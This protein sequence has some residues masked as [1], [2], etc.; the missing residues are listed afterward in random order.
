[1]QS[2]FQHRALFTCQRL[3]VHD[4]SIRAEPKYCDL[5]WVFCWL[6]ICDGLALLNWGELFWRVYNEYL[7]TLSQITQFFLIIIIFFFRAPSFVP[8]FVLS[9]SLFFYVFFALRERQLSGLLGLPAFASI[10]SIMLYCKLLVWWILLL[11]FCLFV[12][13]VIWK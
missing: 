7:D 4:W 6:F 11:M 3:I 2:S 8:S 12:I 5:R 10:L 9:V 1:M 13:F